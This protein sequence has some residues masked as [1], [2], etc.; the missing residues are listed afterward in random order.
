MREK[1]KHPLLV[2]ID[3]GVT[4]CR[5]GVVAPSNGKIHG[6]TK[7]KTGGIS[8]SQFCDALARVADPYRK[9]LVG[10]GVAVPGFCDHGQRRVVT[11]CGTVPFLESCNLSDSVMRRLGVPTWVDNDARAHAV[12]EFEYGGWGKPRS[13]VVMTLGTGVGLAWHIEG[14]LYPPPD[15]GAQGGH[16]AVSWPDRN[17][18]YCGMA[19]CLESLAGGT[20]IAAA[21]EERLARFNPSRLKPPVNAQ[22]VCRF[23]ARDVVAKS[24]IDRAVESL[25]C[26]LHTLHHLYFPDVLVLGGSVSV[27]LWPY[28]ASLRKWFARLDRYDGRHN[29]LVLSRLG[30]KAGVLGAAALVRG[31]LSQPECP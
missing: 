6:L 29:R 23:G 11:T 25:R 17:P 19:G 5:I 20:A 18:C 12:G 9:D 16:I 14:R 31:S 10:I 28:L 8:L 1:S 30:D 21:A 26:A 22:Q 7:H 24:C 2:G 4:H 3:I 13:Q 15:H 27:G